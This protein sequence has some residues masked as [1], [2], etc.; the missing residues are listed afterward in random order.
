VVDL[1]SAVMA[2]DE[3][4]AKRALIVAAMEHRSR[5]LSGDER[6]AW[7]RSGGRLALDLFDLD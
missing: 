1:R 2:L 4:S 5:E 3:T 6:F 7:M